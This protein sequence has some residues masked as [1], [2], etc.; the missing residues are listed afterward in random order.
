MVMTTMVAVT[1]TAANAG[2]MIVPWKNVRSGLCLDHNFTDGLHMRGC[3]SGP[4]QKWERTWYASDGRTQWMNSATK[5]CLDGSE[6][7]VRAFG[8]NTLP[9][10]RWKVGN[11]GNYRYE[12]VNNFTSGCLDYSEHGLRSFGCNGSPYQLWTHVL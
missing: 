5:M 6:K 7:G 3:N 2:D 11:W 8:C 9:Y 12:L 1:P 10:Q 4:Y